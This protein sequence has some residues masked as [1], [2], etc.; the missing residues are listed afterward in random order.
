ML[1]N[2]SDFFTSLKVKYPRL[3]E[4]KERESGPS[5]FQGMRFCRLLLKNLSWSKLQ[6]NKIEDE[7]PEISNADWPD[8]PGGPRSPLA[9]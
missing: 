2:L 8:S 7:F 6:K 4:G 9:V 1:R 5:S 3:L